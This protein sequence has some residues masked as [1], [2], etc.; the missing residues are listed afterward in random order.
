MTQ[1]LLDTFPQYSIRSAR[2]DEVEALQ[3]I[4][5]ESSNLFIG[6]NLIDFGPSS[7]Q[8]DPIPETRIRQ[9]FGDQLVWTAIDDRDTPVGF[10]LCAHRAE[11]LYLDQVSVLPSYGQQGIGRLLVQQAIDAAAAH[12]YK[13]LTLSTFRDVPWNGPFYKKLG[14]KEIPRYRLKPWQIELEKLQSSTMDVRK[15]C[16][17]QKTV[18]RLFF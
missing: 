5:I 3:K 4:D 18:K 7:A 13:H 10:A 14:F 9:G 12:G 17:M 15:R 16:F 11:C 1:A 8:L 2:A 6:T